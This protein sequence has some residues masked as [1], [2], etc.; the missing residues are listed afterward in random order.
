MITLECKKPLYPSG[1]REAKE[2]PLKEGLKYL[3]LHSLI[4]ENNF[5]FSSSDN[6]QY[7]IYGDVVH[8]SMDFRQKFAHK[9]R[10]RTGEQFK[11][12]F[13]ALFHCQSI[14]QFHILYSFMVKEELAEMQKGLLEKSNQIIP[15]AI[16]LWV[17]PKIEQLSPTLYKYFD[18]YVLSFVNIMGIPVVEKNNFKELFYQP[19]EQY[20]SLS[21]FQQF[22]QNLI[23]R[24]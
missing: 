23:N 16:E 9:Y 15:S 20:Q 7:K 5:K 21:L 8:K 6:Y 14:S 4:F 2:Y 24:L 11:V 3:P 18:E 19:H 22:Q 12:Y 17:S 10:S 13:G 1:I